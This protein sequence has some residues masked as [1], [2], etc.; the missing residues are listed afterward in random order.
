M[1]DNDVDGFV[2]TL[3]ELIQPPNQ[4]VNESTA[5]TFDSDMH[6][7]HEYSK[8]AGLS[9]SYA[10]MVFDSL[11]DESPLKTIVPFVLKSVLGQRR[12]QTSMFLL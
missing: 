1:N 6:A 10:K 9:T 5:P 7:K 3:H 11:H 12:E 2:Q 4:N 8:P